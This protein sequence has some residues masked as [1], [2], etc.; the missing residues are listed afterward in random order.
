MIGVPQ[1]RMWGPG[2]EPASISRWSSN[3]SG[4]GAPQSR[5][6]VIPDSGGACRGKARG[7]DCCLRTMA[8]AAQ[9]RQIEEM[10]GR[11]GNPSR[12]ARS[13]ARLAVLAVL[14]APPATKPG[15]PEGAGVILK[16]AG[17]VA[18]A[19]LGPTLEHEHVFVRA[20]AETPP[21]RPAAPE[22]HTR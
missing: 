6:V 16:V 21:R 7:V 1:A 2:V 22:R 3:T 13:R 12:L 10:T 14:L 18:P 9:N 11:P 17:P 20:P 15:P 19:T 8:V 5:I 4:A